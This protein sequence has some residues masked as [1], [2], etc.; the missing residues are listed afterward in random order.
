MA[1]APYGALYTAPP[2]SSTAPPTLDALL[3]PGIK[4]VRLQW[5]DLINTPRT[6]VLSAAYFR[7]L[8][9]HPGVRAGVG[10]PTIAL[11]LVGLNVADGFGAVGEWLFVPD[12]RSWRVCLYA[13]ASGGPTA[14]ATA[15]VMGWFEEKTP[16]PGRGLEVPLCPRTLLRRLVT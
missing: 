12:L 16:R 1:S 8:Y 14:M 10:I 15:C 3:T 13:S 7:K 5:I 4:Y 6:R 2:P 11:G 9:A